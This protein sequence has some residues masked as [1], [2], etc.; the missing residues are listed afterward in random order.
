MLSAAARFHCM[1]PFCGRLLSN[2]HRTLL[3]S[4]GPMSDVD[5]RYL[6]FAALSQPTMGTILTINLPQKEVKQ[7]IQVY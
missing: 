4:N 6:V 7:L 2:H 1:K 3:A 5:V